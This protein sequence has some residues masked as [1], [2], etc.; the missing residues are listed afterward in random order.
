MA[1][2]VVALYYGWT[3]AGYAEHRFDRIHKH[4]AIP[5]DVPEAEIPADVLR[6]GRVSV[7]H[8]VASLGMAD[9]NSEARRLIG[10]RGVKIDGKVVDDPEAELPLGE[11]AGRVIQ[12]GR[13]QFRKL[14]AS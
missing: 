6:D 10:Q 5:A 4:G 3:E 1:K 13:R 14:R 9:S 7:P 8:L 11:L 2:W 12:V